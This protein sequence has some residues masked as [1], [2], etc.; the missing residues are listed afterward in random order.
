MNQLSHC[1]AHVF[2]LTA[3]D[4]SDDWP[5]KRRHTDLRLFMMVV[6]G[7][8]DREPV[9]AWLINIVHIGSTQTAVMIAAHVGQRGIWQKFDGQIGDDPLHWELEDREPVDT[10]LVVN[11]FCASNRSDWADAGIIKEA[12]FFNLH[13]NCMYNRTQMWNVKVLHFILLACLVCIS[14]L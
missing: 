10:S 5:A 12:P 6:W 8:R 1:D 7:S 11:A 14:S 3:S 9:N 13:K 4:C 2:V